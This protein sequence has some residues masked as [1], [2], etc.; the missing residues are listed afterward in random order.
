MGVTITALSLHSATEKISTSKIYQPRHYP[1]ERDAH[2]CETEIASLP[3]NSKYNAT[4]HP[5]ATSG[6]PYNVSGKFVVPQ[7]RCALCGFYVV[8]WDRKSGAEGCALTPLCWLFLLLCAF[9]ALSAPLV[10][11]RL[12]RLCLKLRKG[13]CPLTLQAL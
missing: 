3:Y 9:V 11:L 1:P 8:L 7:N 6:R 10:G 12:L 13:L 2:F 5:R 4:P